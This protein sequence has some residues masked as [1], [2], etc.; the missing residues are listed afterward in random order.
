MKTRF[1]KYQYGAEG[2]TGIR[3]SLMPAIKSSMAPVLSGVLSEQ[4]EVKPQGAIKISI[5]NVTPK[6]K[7]RKSRNLMIYRDFAESPSRHNIS[8]VAE[9]FL[10]SLIRYLIFDAFL[11]LAHGG[12]CGPSVADKYAGKSFSTSAPNIPSRTEKSRQFDC[13]IRQGGWGV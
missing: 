13:R 12:D 7:F 1:L 3:P 4:S 8:S 6:I 10:I 2:I 9:V 5:L 11:R